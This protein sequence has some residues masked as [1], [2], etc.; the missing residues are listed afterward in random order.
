MKHLIAHSVTVAHP[1]KGMKYVFL[2]TLQIPIG[3][4]S[5]EVL[6]LN[7][8]WNLRSIAEALERDLK[9]IFPDH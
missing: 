6:D 4:S 3:E 7:V 5:R 9:G 1:K 8:Q 2:P